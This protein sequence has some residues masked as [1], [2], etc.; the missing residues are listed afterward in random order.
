MDEES[1]D[2]GTR[3]R[4]LQEELS[5]LNQL[6][7]NRGFKRLMTYAE[8][9]LKNRR[10]SVLL[11]PLKAMDEVLEQEYSKGEIAGIQL[12][13]EMHATASAAIEDE[14]AELLKEIENVSEKDDSTE[15]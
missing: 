6:K 1:T 2:A 11:T 10:D 13:T 9:Q 7:A 14:I 3:L 8:V 4:E 12:F 15:S 5:D